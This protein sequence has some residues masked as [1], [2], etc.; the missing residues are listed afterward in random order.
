MKQN[1]W[2]W[3]YLGAAAAVAL[4]MASR[5]QAAPLSIY[6]SMAASSTQKAPAAAVQPMGLFSSIQ[7]QEQ[8]A[9]LSQC[10]GSYPYCTPLMPDTSLYGGP[11][12]VLPTTG[13]ARST[14]RGTTI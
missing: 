2:T 3:I 11:A 12:V 10:V 5:P 9:I 13:V 6:P 7:Q 1:D 8:T 4:Y 14:A